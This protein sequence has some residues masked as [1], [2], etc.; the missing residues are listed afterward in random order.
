MN[1]TAMLVLI[2][3]KQRQHTTTNALEA[4]DISG[5]SQEP[6]SL[7]VKEQ[8][9]SR[10]P[11]P[12]TSH[13]AIVGNARR[14]SLLPQRASVGQSSLARD[15]VI[16]EFDEKHKSINAISGSGQNGGGHTADT[17]LGKRSHYAE[18][19]ENRDRST[20]AP[21]PVTI[22]KIDRSIVMHSA[23]SNSMAPPSVV[24]SSQSLR[25]PMNYEGAPKAVSRGHARNI[26]AIV[27]SNN[28]T[29]SNFQRRQVS[30][31]AASTCPPLWLNSGS[32]QGSRPVSAASCC[33]SETRTSER[34]SAGPP[35]NKGQ[36][37]CANGLK[38]VSSTGT[39]HA[40]TDSQTPRD[41]EQSQS[42]RS[43]LASATSRSTSNHVKK[44]TRPAFSTLQQ[45]FTPKKTLKA[46]T[47]SFVAVSP[48]KVA[49]S[50][51]LSSE[52]VRLQTELLQLH[53]LHRSSAEVQRQWESSAESKLRRQ[54]EVV[55]AR[56]RELTLSGSKAQDR[57]DLLALKDW[58]YSGQNLELAERVQVLSRTIQELYNTGDAG[59]K[60]NHIVTSFE[61]WIVGNE[62]IWRMR[63]HNDPNEPQDMEFVEDVG[64]C[65]KAE[66]AALERRL[67]SCSRDL[68]CL[69][70]P[71]EGSTL[72]YVVGICTTLVTQMLE[73][74]KVMRDIECEVLE[75]E[76]TWVMEMI[77]RIDLE[78]A[79]LGTRRA[80]WQSG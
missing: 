30:N 49:N 79:M 48:T 69:G 46:P 64:D 34:P 80:V 19:S 72:A 78:S 74:L 62:R 56:H 50:N 65:W 24:G 9:P 45:Q 25:K 11:V 51:V 10:L 1:I 3:S 35:N 38:R 67:T 58:K 76:K 23:R 73:E 53:L 40:R 13:D 68:E 17:E 61:R 63:E 32:N 71:L 60:F 37:S 57:V 27:K 22:G 66:A 43:S 12:G 33:S 28:C 6:A 55:A 70:Q 4:T 44:P 36:V 75:R 18:K 5:I 42:Q 14:R 54:Y 2:Y 15:I 7:V 41:R 16:D 52:T 20:Q 29:A 8:S 21:V 31:A 26:S 77:D 39:K 47:A 59:G